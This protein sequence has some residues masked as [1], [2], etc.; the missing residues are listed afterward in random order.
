MDHCDAAAFAL[1]RVSAQGVSSSDGGCK[2]KPEPDAST[3]PLTQGEVLATSPPHNG[4]H[5]GRFTGASS[6]PTPRPAPSTGRL[7][8]ASFGRPRTNLSRIAGGRCQES[9]HSQP[10]RGDL[11]P[12]G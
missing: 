1:V 6:P 5:R 4:E 11:P 8:E 3:V 2:Q 7:Q 9:E 12:H 10:G